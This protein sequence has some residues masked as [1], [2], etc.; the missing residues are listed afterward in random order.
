MC[1]QSYHATYVGMAIITFENP[2]RRSTE[3]KQLRYY[4]RVIHK[5]YHHFPYVASNLDLVRTRR[6]GVGGKGGREGGGLLLWLLLCC[7]GC[8]AILR[9]DFL[10]L[11]RYFFPIP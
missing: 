5:I 10:V 4:R 7:Y 6:V 1:E 11:Y 8:Y 3:A 2:S 9:N